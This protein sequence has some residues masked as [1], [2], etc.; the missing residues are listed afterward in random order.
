[1]PWRCNCGLI[2]ASINKHCAGI[3]HFTNEHFQ[4]TASNYD[5]TL[6]WTRERRFKELT[7]NEDKFAQFFNAET[8]LVS[9]MSDVELIEHITELEEIAFEAKAR[10]TAAKTG[11]RDRSA[12]KRLG[13][14]WTISPL[15]PDQTVTDSINR[16]ELRG[17]RMT[18]LDKTRAKL[19]ALG[20]SDKDIDLMINTM[21]KQARK[22]P[23]TN[24]DSSAT[25]VTKPKPI[26]PISPVE[27]EPSQ[28]NPLDLSKLKFG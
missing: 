23:P 16:V 11:Q 27:M 6:Y 10:L 26:S 9:A 3:N 22:D 8:V 4:I 1:M 14:E 12:K 20:L 13:G 17:K 18:K 2:N 25:A 24:G 15:Q 28:S 19:E 21:L 5:S 7:D